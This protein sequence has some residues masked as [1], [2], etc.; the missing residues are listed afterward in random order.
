MADLP[1]SSGSSKLLFPG[2]FIL[3]SLLEN[4]LRDFNVL[5]M[6]KNMDVRMSLLVNCI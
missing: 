5:T 1:G 6:I 4:S 2:F 3:L